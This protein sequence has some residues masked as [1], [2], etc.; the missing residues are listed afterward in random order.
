MD[1][2]EIY[3]VVVAHGEINI[4]DENVRKIC[5]VTTVDEERYRDVLADL[6][7]R[8]VGSIRTLVD[9]LRRSLWCCTVC[10]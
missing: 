4:V 1:K 6:T 8:W 5:G 7:F 3:D 10:K 2:Q 9:T